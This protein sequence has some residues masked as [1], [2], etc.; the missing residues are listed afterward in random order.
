MQSRKMWRK[1][2]EQNEP[3]KKYKNNWKMGN[4]LR[5]SVYAIRKFRNAN[6]SVFV[7]S[8]N[9]QHEW[10]HEILL[11]FIIIIRYD[12]YEFNDK[13]REKCSGNLFVIFGMSLT[14]FV[15]TFTVTM[16][17]CKNCQKL[18]HTVTT[19]FRIFIDWNA[20]PGCTL[21]TVFTAISH[22]KLN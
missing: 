12:Y 5:R 17:W 21:H 13:R 20:V 2:S 4:S 3:V 1:R 8:L 19:I 11:L 15:V 18:V 6:K 14:I 16:M 22:F 10:H 7:R 9:I